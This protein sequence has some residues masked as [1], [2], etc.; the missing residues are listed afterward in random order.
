MDTSLAGTG[1]HRRGRVGAPASAC[2][3]SWRSAD[4]PGSR[5]PWRH[6]S[7]RCGAA[8]RRLPARGGHAWPCVVAHLSCGGYGA[9][10]TLPLGGPSPS[11]GRRAELPGQLPHVAATSTRTQQSWQGKSPRQQSRAKG[12]KTCSLRRGQVRSQIDRSSN[13]HASDF[14]TWKQKLTPRSPRPAA[15]RPRCVCRAS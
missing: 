15:A 14:N 10:D 7:W 9:C 8:A 4:G 13:K 12:Q 2:P 3:L 11:A 6:A 5:A 1:I